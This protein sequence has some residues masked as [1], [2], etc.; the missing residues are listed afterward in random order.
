MAA[1][2]PTRPAP[3]ARLVGAPLVGALQKGTHEG[4]PYETLQS[5]AVGKD[6]ME[7]PGGCIMRGG[8]GPKGHWKLVLS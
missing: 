7:F 8:G 3:V 6:T 2:H 5:S 4:C 1:V